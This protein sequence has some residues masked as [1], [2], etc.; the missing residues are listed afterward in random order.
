[1]IQVFR[2]HDGSHKQASMGKGSTEKILTD[3]FSMQFLFVVAS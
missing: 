3:A 1:M 2:T